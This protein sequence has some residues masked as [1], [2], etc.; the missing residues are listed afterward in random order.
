LDDKGDEN[1]NLEQGIKS[2]LFLQPTNR[3]AKR[4]MSNISNFLMEEGLGKERKTNKNNLIYIGNF[5]TKTS[6]G[7][8]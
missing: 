4:V 1:P 2:M 3:K 5:G 6:T 8:L 7:N